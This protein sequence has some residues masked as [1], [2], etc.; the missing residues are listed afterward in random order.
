MTYNEPERGDQ[1]NVSPQVAAS[2]W[3]DIVSIAREYN[4]EIVAPCGTIDLG[5]TWYHKWLDECN[6]LYSQPCQYNYTYLHAYFQPEPCIGVASWACIGHTGGNAMTKIDVWYEDFGKPTWV[7]EF[8]CNPWGGVSCNATKYEE[9][10]IQFIPLLDDSDAVYRYAWFSADAFDF[11]EANTNEIAWQ[12]SYQEACPNK[13]WITGVGD[14]AWQIQ[15][16]SE[17]LQ[18]ADTN[19]ECHTLLILNMDD[20]NCYCSVD[21]CISPVTSY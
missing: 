7:T 2:Q 4:L 21:D 17:C 20:D 1:A 12:F 14:A 11:G 16:I 13:T 10:M 9:L 5:S 19:E 15:S 6:D 3:P 18:I 8:A